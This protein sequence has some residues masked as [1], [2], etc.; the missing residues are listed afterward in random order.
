MCR[1]S[2]RHPDNRAHG[3]HIGVARRPA[4][5]KRQPSRRDRADDRIAVIEQRAAKIGGAARRLVRLRL[6]RP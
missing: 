3:W 5:R 4:E 6:S 1:R 2:A